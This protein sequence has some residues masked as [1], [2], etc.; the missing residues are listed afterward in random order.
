LIQDVCS[1]L[2]TDEHALAG[3]L[4]SKLSEAEGRAIKL[5]TP[6]KDRHPNG[7][8]GMSAVCLDRQAPGSHS[9]WFGPTN[10]SLRLP[11]QCRP[12]RATELLRLPTFSDRAH[13]DLVR[14]QYI[15]HESIQLLEHPACTATWPKMLIRVNINFGNLIVSAP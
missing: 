11:L 12:N 9:E 4:A 14:S 5:L 10:R 2:K 7:A 6:P 15:C 13:R 1:W 8:V 3:G